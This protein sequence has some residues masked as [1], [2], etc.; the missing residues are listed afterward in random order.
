MKKAI[1]ILFIIVTFS[2]QEI[3]SNPLTKFDIKT[4]FMDKKFL[5]YFKNGLIYF[6]Q[7]DGRIKIVETSEH[8][9]IWLSGN[10]PI[11]RND[12]YIYYVKI[13]ICKPT[14]FPFEQRRIIKSISGPIKITPKIYLQYENMN[15]PPTRADLVVNQALLIYGMV[16]PYLNIRPELGLLMNSIKNF[17][18]IYK[19]KPPTA[20]EIAM[21]LYG[22][23]ILY[24]NLIK[25]FRFP[26]R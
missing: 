26:T 6:L 24:R 3:Y 4:R 7:R 21:A 1:N 17:L 25:M 23:E 12:I 5:T 18:I 13:D 22:G 9:A 10:L 15:L 14:A 11:L 8:Y 20:L 2:F 19:N 16:K